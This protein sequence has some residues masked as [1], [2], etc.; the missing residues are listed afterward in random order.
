MMTDQ[1]AAVRHD[2]FAQVNDSVRNLQSLAETFQIV[3]AMMA[4]PQAAAGREDRGGGRRSNRAAWQPRQRSAPPTEEELANVECWRC[5]G[6][7]HYANQCNAVARGRPQGAQPPAGTAQAAP[8][9]DVLVARVDRLCDQQEQTLRA[10]TALAETRA[11]TASNPTPTVDVELA[12]QVTSLTESVSV[13]TT[14]VESVNSQFKAICGG[15]AE[16]KESH[17]VLET[18]LRTATHGLKKMEE[19]MEKQGAKITASNA[20]VKDA[21]H[22]VKLN[23]AKVKSIER[24][25]SLFD[26]QMGHVKSLDGLFHATVER[27]EDW[28]AKL[29]FRTATIEAHLG[30]AV[31]PTPATPGGTVQMAGTNK[32]PGSGARAGARK[33]PRLT[34]VTEESPLFPDTPA[35]RL[36]GSG[37]KKASMLPSPLVLP[38]RKK[39]RVVAP[40]PL[41]GTGEDRDAERLDEMESGG[42]A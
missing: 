16:A 37:G 4:P 31:Q 38:K 12:S 9:N 20:A 39:K 42:G 27:F 40:T 23:E 19:K 41:V 30:M 25:L 2:P 26:A 1:Q 21:E 5:R 35:L 17:R 36:A 24:Q 28:F 7:G 11:V 13:L 29:H 8:A 34:T 14:A 18:G 33:S 6:F 15:I 32:S 22:L 10:L 3:Q